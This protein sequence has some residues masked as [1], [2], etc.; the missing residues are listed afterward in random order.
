MNLS[1]DFKRVLRHFV[2]YYT[3]GTLPY[4]IGDDDLLKGIDYREDLK[5]EASIVEQAFAIFIN[6]I[7]MDANGTVINAQY[8][9]LRAA[10]LIRAVCCEPE[11]NF[12]VDP[13]F[14]DW[15]T[16]LH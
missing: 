1:N 12:K 15:E 7:K 10:Q 3:N 5:E 13:D 2:Y 11:D 8:A 16:E 4:V 6:N 14:Q 9:M